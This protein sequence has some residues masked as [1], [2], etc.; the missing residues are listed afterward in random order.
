MVNLVCLSSDLVQPELNLTS[1]SAE[2]RPSCRRKFQNLQLYPY[3]ASGSCLFKYRSCLK[4]GL[5]SFENCAFT[6][7]IKTYNRG[8]M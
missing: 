8:R 7:P 4:V 1:L 2:I 5:I 6:I 3:L